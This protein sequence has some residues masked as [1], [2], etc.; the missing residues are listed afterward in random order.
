MLM[1]LLDLQFETG[2]QMCF[3]VL[4]VV[5]H[6]VCL[7]YEYTACLL[8]RLAWSLTIDITSV[9]LWAYEELYRP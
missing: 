5:S 7:Q 6:V 9:L 8:G 4:Y 1:S 3:L 2:S